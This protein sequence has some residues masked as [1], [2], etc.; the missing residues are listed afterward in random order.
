VQDPSAGKLASV[1]APQPVVYKPPRRGSP[2]ARVGGGTRARRAL[3]QPLVLAPSPALTERASP[4][5]FWHLDG[6]PG[7]SVQVEFTLIELD[8][9]EPLVEKTLPQPSGAGIRRIRL[10]ELGVELAPEREYEWFISLVPSPDNKSKDIVSGASIIRV[11]GAIPSAPRSPQD[12]AERGL[13]YDALES[14]MDAL[15]EQPGSQA[16]AA[17]RDS[18]LRQGGLG[19]ATP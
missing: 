7:G 8:G 1:S 5:L 9:I 14:L 15:D 17:E 6:D 10:S 2:R 18:L 4:S 19:A 16:I 3:P 11:A 12:Y 13:W